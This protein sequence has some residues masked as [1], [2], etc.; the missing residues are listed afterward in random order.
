MNE[1]D[2]IS[3]ELETSRYRNKVNSDSIIDNQLFM[4]LNYTIDIAEY[5]HKYWYEIKRINIP[6]DSNYL[7]KGW[8]QKFVTIAAGDVAGALTGIQSGLVATATVFFVTMGW[9]SCISW[10]HC[11]WI[12]EFSK[13]FKMINN[14][15]WLY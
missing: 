4:W 2:I 3:F 7:A 11:D 13:N 14:N 9:Y 1:G 5:F 15:V 6:N 12:I 10:N 8:Q